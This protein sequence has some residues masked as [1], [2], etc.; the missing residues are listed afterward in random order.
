MD[1]V[2]KINMF[3]VEVKNINCYRKDGYQSVVRG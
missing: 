2:Y 3:K 1:Q